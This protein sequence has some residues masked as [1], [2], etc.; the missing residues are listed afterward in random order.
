MMDNRYKNLKNVIEQDKQYILI[1]IMIA[2]WDIETDFNTAKAE[3]IKKM[4]EKI[5]INKLGYNFQCFF[6]ELSEIFDL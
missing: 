3:A 6:R 1:K 4:L 2:C 5:E